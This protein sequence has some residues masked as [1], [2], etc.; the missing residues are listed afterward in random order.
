MEL[1]KIDIDEKGIKTVNARY[2]WEFLGSKQEFSNWIKARIRDY[3]FEK[4]NDFIVFDKV[5]NNPNGGRPSEEY[6]LTL[7]TAKE[8][9]MVERNAKGKEA[10]LYF[11]A[12]EKKVSKELTRLELIDML[13]D[14]EVKKLAALELN[15][16]LNQK[17]EKDQPKIEF[18]ESIRHTK[19]TVTVQEFSK[20]LSQEGLKIGQNRL[21]ASLRELGILMTDNTPYQR[22]IDNHWMTLDE[23]PYKRKDGTEAISK[24][25]LITGKGQV[26][27]WK[28]LAKQAVNA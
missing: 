15:K 17:I 12:C 8:L 2:L 28:K 19:A 9:S 18:A 21:F 14:T 3:G 25:S 23:F 22:Y 16:E 13:R 24:R 4:G 26:G 1:I 6:H 5:V 11:I 27:L 7:D 20:I 10:R